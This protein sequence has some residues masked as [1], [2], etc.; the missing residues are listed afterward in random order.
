MSAFG[1]VVIPMS[2]KNVLRDKDTVDE[3]ALE[4]IRDEDRIEPELRR[5][6]EQEIQGKVDANHP[7]SCRSSMTLAQE[8][9]AIARELEIARTRERVATERAPYR[10]EGSRVAVRESRR[11]ARARFE[12]RAASVDRWQ[13]PDRDD[14][15]A[16][17][18]QSEVATVNEQAERLADELD[19]WTQAA[20]S[21]RLAERLVDGRDI[22]DAVVDVYDE[23]D[24][25]AGTV[26]PIAKVG[27][28]NRGEVSISGEVVEL[29]NASS[30]RVQDVGLI[31]DDSGRIKVT[32]WRKSDASVL[33]KGEDVVLRNVAKSW[34]EG[35]C[36]VA[37]TG[38]S[39]IEFPERGRWWA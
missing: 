35:R 31:E 27:E 25:A 21:R 34:Y 16:M 26:I 11:Q 8:E 12:E 38:W 28:V 33:Q 36:S 4:Q 32:V 37:V 10:E 6:V 39:Q 23:L 1:I 13:A 7:D 15:R 19:G 3:Q 24:G 9:E 2:G 29:W 5:S 18:S 30:P 14:P 22:T 20:I 17:L